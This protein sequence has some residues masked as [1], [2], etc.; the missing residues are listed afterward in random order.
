VSDLS[1]AARQ[2]LKYWP[3]IE[4][5]AQSR[6]STADLWSAIRDAADELGLSSPGVT[7]NGVS[8]LRGL[9]SG[10]QRRGEAVDRAHDSQRLTDE[11]MAQAP[12]SRPLPQQ[13]AFPMFQVRF[14]HTFMQD[15][16]ERSEWRTSVF[17][18]RLP[19]TAGELRAAIDMD[20]NELAS[21]YGST[22]VGVGNL[23]ILQV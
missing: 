4:F 5:A 22:H 21:K 18:G 17:N 8:T 3:Q 10:I 14:Q 7:A 2:A 20:A 9:A 11:H 15:G 19:R 12:W 23:Q 13:N 6:M 16:E 1:D